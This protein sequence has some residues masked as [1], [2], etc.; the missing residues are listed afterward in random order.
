MG[1]VFKS[2]DTLSLTSDR[3][4]HLL[5]ILPIHYGTGHGI[6][7]AVYNNI[8]GSN[9]LNTGDFFFF[10]CLR[11]AAF[12][13]T[14]R[15]K[16]QYHLTLTLTTDDVATIPFHLTLSAA[17]LGVSPNFIPVHSLMVSSHLFSCSSISCFFHCPLQNCLCHARG[18]WD[19]AIPSEF[20]FLHHG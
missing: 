10:F 11:V 12:K 16:L 3:F 19:V 13:T 18:S 9:D 7:V 14:V 5:L 2:F 8:W 17:A 20:Q 4:V 1:N 15:I 6:L